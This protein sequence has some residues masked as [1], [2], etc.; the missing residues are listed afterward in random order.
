MNEKGIF[1]RIKIKLSAVF[2]GEGGTRDCR[3]RTFGRFVGKVSA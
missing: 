3:W 1:I 2:A